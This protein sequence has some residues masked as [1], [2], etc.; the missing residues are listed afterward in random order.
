MRSGLLVFLLGVACGSAGA[1]EAP[2]ACGSAQDV[3]QRYVNALGG[4]AAIKQVKSLRIEAS[5]TEPH[6][7]DPQSMAHS[8]YWFEWQAPNRMR[9]HRHYLLSPA[10]VI[11]DGTA[12]S[13]HNGHAGHNQ[14]PTPEWQRKL[15]QLPYND[16]PE[17]QEF[18]VMANPLLLTVASEL[19]QELAVVPGEPGTCVVGGS[20]TNERGY[21]RR[22][23]L[24][25]DERSG[26][27][28]SWRIQAELRQGNYFEFRF[29]DYRQAG[30]I[31]IPY[32]VYY[33]FYR[34][35]FRVTK[36][37]VNVPIPNS[38]FVPKP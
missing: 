13:Q 35:L 32:S 17:M 33:D 21:Q 37:A 5:E 3:I 24:A 22:D 38:D 12:W 16:F 18:R 8:R 9:V 1:Q 20:G 19:Y 36:V 28:R 31:V 23:F 15:R 6:T 26:L 34:A 29:D 14:D 2:A 4:E 27:L 10:T 25:F 11:F 30:Q 7:F